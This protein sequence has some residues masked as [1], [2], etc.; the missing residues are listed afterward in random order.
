[1][2]NLTKKSLLNSLA[3][4][5]KFC[6][7]AIPFV[8]ISIDYNK[9]NVKVFGD[10]NYSC[11]FT[12]PEPINQAIITFADISDLTN[13][14]RSIPGESIF[15][16]V[17]DDK[18]H[19]TDSDRMVS[20]SFG[21]S[22]DEVTFDFIMPDSMKAKTVNFEPGELQ[23]ILGK[24]AH[25]MSKEDVRYYLNG[26]YFDLQSHKIVAANGHV[27]AIADY[28]F[29]SMDEISN[30]ILPRQA[31]EGI[32][33]SSFP[34][35]APVSLTTDG[36]RIVLTCQDHFIVSKTV[37]DNFPKYHRIIKTEAIKTEPIENWVAAS[38]GEKI[39]F[40]RSTLLKALKAMK[41]GK[42]DTV[43]ITFLADNMAELSKGALTYKVSAKITDSPEKPIDYIGFNVKYL[44]SVAEVLESDNLV[45]SPTLYQ[46]SIYP[47]DPIIIADNQVYQVLMPCR[48]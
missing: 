27:M 31:I 33:S 36:H 4:A 11:D 8:Q 21:E 48:I 14:I 39:T 5:K 43:K 19:V 38:H 23:K 13:L 28:T 26:I 9:M 24:I 47:T 20:S 16:S 46:N 6:D 10:V 35:T 3:L 41:A 45:M 15:L 34:K 17:Q 7:K 12:L 1:M 18:I 32:L 25:A 42:N 29:E 30:F 40:Q 22:R 44:I 37:E 2:T